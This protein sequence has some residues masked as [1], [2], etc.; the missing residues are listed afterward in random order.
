MSYKTEIINTLE[1]LR[2]KFVSEHDEIK[3]TEVIKYVVTLYK[4][5]LHSGNSNPSDNIYSGLKYFVSDS[6]VANSLKPIDKIIIDELVSTIYGDKCIDHT[7]YNFLNTDMSVN[8][9]KDKKQII[10]IEYPKVS[11]MYSLENEIK[12]IT[13]RLG[14]VGLI[15]YTKLFLRYCS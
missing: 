11:A 14:V 7:M 6:N 2:I 15:E 10:K 3:T 5:K 9:V 4:S 8:E 1:D 13:E 12:I